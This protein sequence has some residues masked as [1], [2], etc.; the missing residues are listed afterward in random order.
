[1]L[2][3]PVFEFLPVEHLIRER[4]QAYYDALALGDDTGDCSAFAAFILDRINT[5]LDQLIDETRGVTLTAT[6]RLGIARQ[7]FGH[8]SF[9]RKDYQNVLKTISAATAS[10]DLRQG[11]EMGMLKRSGD[12]R[13][14]VYRF[15]VLSD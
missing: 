1:M 6:N 5:S 11:V 14:S 15:K 2:Y 9:S 10:R 7:A 13:T 8:K 4:Q 3:H 12:K